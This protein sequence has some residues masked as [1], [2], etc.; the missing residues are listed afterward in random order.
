MGRLRVTAGLAL[1][2][3]AP[4]LARATTYRNHNGWWH[5]KRCRPCD[6]GYAR[7]HG[8][9]RQGISEA[10]GPETIGVASWYDDRESTACG[11]H[12][13]SGV[14]SL[15]LPC[16]ARLRLCHEATCEEATVQDR[17]PYVE[18]RILDLNPGAKAGIAC[19]DLC[20]VRFS[21]VR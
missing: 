21:V 8:R 11:T 1:A 9:A 12:Y 18:G 5:G 16:G 4:A 14:A 15:S 17:G 10:Q 19:S 20:T 6:R 7:L 3:C 13:A 2:L